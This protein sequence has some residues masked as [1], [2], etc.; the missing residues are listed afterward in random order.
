[1]GCDIHFY[2]EQKINGKWVSADTFEKTGDGDDDVYFRQKD[3]Y[4]G[5]RNYNLFAI[6][7]DVRNGRGFA[8][9]KTGDGFNPI[10]A[11][12][13]LPEDVSME[14]R[15][16]SD[17]MG[18]DGHSHS[19]FTLRE[20]LDYDWTQTTKLSGW[21]DLSAWAQWS[22]WDREHGKGP[23]SWC[24]DVWGS[25]VL[26]LSV[27]EMDKLTETY[28]TFLQAGDREGAEAFLK[29]NNAYGMAEWETPYYRAGGSFLDETIPR[30]L[31]LAGGTKGIDDVRIV[32][33]FDN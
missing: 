8:G 25:Q 20:L 28:N 33:F 3:E 1:M 11:P 15:R 27:A 10:S 4:Y 26:K 21:V 29:S 2:V 23:E 24:G 22:R 17:G 30:L 16:Q 13:G 19:W 31:K 7:A 12:R 18:C 5:D 9:V 6:L 14:T 32:F